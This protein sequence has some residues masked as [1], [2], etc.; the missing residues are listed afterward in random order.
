[1][2]ERVRE[3]NRFQK[4]LEGRNIKLGSVISD[5]LRVFGR[6]MLKNL[7]EGG[8]R[9]PAP[10]R[11]SQMGSLAPATKPVVANGCRPGNRARSGLKHGSGLQ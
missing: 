5:T 9:S 6:A 10:R 8:K 7:A 11:V 1:M 4:V 2:E 3:V